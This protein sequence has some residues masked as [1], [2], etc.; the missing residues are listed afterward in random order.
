MGL[1][2][3]TT[4]LKKWINDPQGVRFS[5][6]ISLTSAKMMLG[7]SRNLLKP[8]IFRIYFIV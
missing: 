6:K 8:D 3:K 1:T 2:A 4:R 7:V 5:D